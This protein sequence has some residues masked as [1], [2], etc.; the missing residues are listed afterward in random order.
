M[1]IRNSFSKNTFGSRKTVSVLRNVRKGGVTLVSLQRK[2]KS[3]AQFASVSV[4]QN[5]SVS[6]LEWGL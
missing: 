1:G 2:G 3:I 6:S 5:K 4:I